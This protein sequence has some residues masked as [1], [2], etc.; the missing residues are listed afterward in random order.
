MHD[1]YFLLKLLYYLS[2]TNSD[3][4]M[5]H[6]V[7]S[8]SYLSSWTK[9]T[10][11]QNHWPRCKVSSKGTLFSNFLVTFFYIYNMG[12]ALGILCSCVAVIYTPRNGNTRNFV[13]SIF[14]YYPIHLFL[15]YNL[16]A[17][18]WRRILFFCTILGKVR[19]IIRRE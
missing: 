10:I 16:H 5:K 6:F 4:Q 1:F 7:L 19:I 17:Y 13:R 3:M 15:E 11:T 9:D 12:T 8:V 18:A 2:E 14:I